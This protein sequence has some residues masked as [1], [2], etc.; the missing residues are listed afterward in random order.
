MNKNY[1]KQEWEKIEENYINAV[2]KIIVPKDANTKDIVLL[3]ASIDRVLTGAIYVQANI[4]NQ[5]NTLDLKIKNSEA[6]LFYSI[7]SNALAQ[8]SK[9]TESE[10]KGMVKDY[11]SKNPIEGY[12]EPCFNKICDLSEKLSFID[13]TIKTLSEKKS[14]LVAIIAMLKLDASFAGI[15]VNQNDIPVDV[16]NI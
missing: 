13:A 2:N 9:L 6:S 10:V 12:D 14:A 3:T 1:T 16:A 4:K 5:Y 7:K 8:G 15:N 11:L